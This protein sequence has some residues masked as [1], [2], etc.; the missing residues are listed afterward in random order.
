MWQKFYEISF[1]KITVRISNWFFNYAIQLDDPNYEGGANPISLIQVQRNFIEFGACE[2]EMI[3][4]V[5]QLVKGE[6]RDDNWKPS[7]SE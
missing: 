1:G 2:R 7:D 4:N 5:S 3:K 6:E